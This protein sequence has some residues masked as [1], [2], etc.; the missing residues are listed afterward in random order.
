MADTPGVLTL[1]GFAPPIRDVERLLRAILLTYLLDW[2]AAIELGRQITD[3]DWERRNGN[4]WSSDLIGRAGFTALGIEG[5]KHPASAEEQ[6]IIDEVRTRWIHRPL[7]DLIKISRSTYPFMVDD[8]PDGA[9]DLPSLAGRYKADFSDQ[10]E[11]V[12]A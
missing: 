8:S 4:P 2:K 9:L 6:T 3:V 7:G 10:R 5:A 11:K 1:L 12:F